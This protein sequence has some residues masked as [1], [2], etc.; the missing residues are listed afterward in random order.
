MIT[1]QK[2]NDL[3]LEMKAAPRIENLNRHITKVEA[4]QK[5]AP[6]IKTMHGN[7][8]APAQIAATLTSA[9]IKIS[10]RGVLQII[11]KKPAMSKP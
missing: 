6:A 3:S 1:L 11:H 5:I 2:I 7:G 8:Y 9:G 10:A 4:L